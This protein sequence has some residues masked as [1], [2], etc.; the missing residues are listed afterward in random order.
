MRFPVKVFSVPTRQDDADV[1][2]RVCMQKWRLICTQDMMNPKVKSAITKKGKSFEIPFKMLVRFHDQ[3]RIIGNKYIK[4][5]FD[6]ESS[7]YT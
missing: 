6:T 7:I 3:R 1:V 4:S 5:S 2:K